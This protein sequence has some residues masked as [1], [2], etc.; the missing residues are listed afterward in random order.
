MR[1][2]FWALRYHLTALL[3][4]GVIW[5]GPMTA[6]AAT[7]DNAKFRIQPN[8]NPVVATLKHFN[9]P[10]PMGLSKQLEA[11][12]EKGAGV[13][14]IRSTRLCAD[15]NGLITVAV[16]GKTKAIV[17][18]SAQAGPVAYPLTFG[19]RYVPIGGGGTGQGRTMRDLPWEGSSETLVDGA[20]VLKIGNV[21]RGLTLPYSVSFGNAPATDVVVTF[22]PTWPGGSATLTIT[23]QGDGNGTAVLVGADSNGELTISKPP[24]NDTLKIQ[25]K[26]VTSTDEGVGPKLQIH[27][28]WTEG[29][30]GSSDSA[31]FAVCAHPSAM[32]FAAPQMVA[33]SI[34]GNDWE[35]GMSMTWSFDSD[36]GN[37]PDIENV[38]AAE[39]V[40]DSLNHGGSMNGHTPLRLAKS[41]NLQLIRLFPGGD[42]NTINRSLLLHI[43]GHGWFDV[44]QL[45][46]FQCNCCKMSGPVEIPN[47]GYSTRVEFG[48]LIEWLIGM[49]K[50]ASLAM[51]KKGADVQIGSNE[52]KAGPDNLQP[53]ELPIPLN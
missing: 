36:T 10:I 44:L 32:R 29:G 51:T 41:T 18:T 21:V 26:G 34:P 11:T 46:V 33:R 31:T 38:N 6:L 37:S 47:S 22:G 17:T 23:H 52:A 3:F 42:T 14:E 35:L 20:T 43:G 30:G 53:I 50:Q 39:R 8:D 24:D 27:G 16:P 25:V 40:S 12:S 4:T 48:Q 1:R 5:L 45:G 7:W 49:P 19:G 28:I 9:K 13:Q 2:N 15:P